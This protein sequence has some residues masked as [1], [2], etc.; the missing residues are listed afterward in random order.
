M[1]LARATQVAIL[2]EDDRQATHTVERLLRVL[3]HLGGRMWLAEGLEMA[4]L[5]VAGGRPRE[6]AEVLAAAQALREALGEEGGQLNAL[7]ERLRACRTRLVASLG[8]DVC[9]GHERRGRTMAPEA[10]VVYALA[11]LEALAKGAN[12][13]DV[14]SGPV[15]SD[16]P[17]S[18]TGPS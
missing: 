18:R 16:R 2:G 9:A 5:V 4:G 13:V 1:A 11:A 3:R 14:R 7:S 6:A 15:R 12:A 10:A 8:S 17:S